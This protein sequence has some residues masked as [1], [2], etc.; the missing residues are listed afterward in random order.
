M[1]TNSV[2]GTMRLRVTLPVTW[3][4]KVKWRVNLNR[5]VILFITSNVQN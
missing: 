5:L 2:L 4:V 3:R 1:K